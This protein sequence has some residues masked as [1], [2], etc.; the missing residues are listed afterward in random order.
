MPYVPS[1][2]LSTIQIDP[3][4]CV[5]NSLSTI[6]NN[7]TLLDFKLSSLALSA[8]LYWNNLYNITTVTSGVWNDLV[9]VVNENSAAWS[10]AY[11]AITAYSACWI[12][13][14]TLIFPNVVDTENLDLEA[15]KV[16]VSSWLN[17]N[18]PVSSFIDSQIVANYCIGQEL[19][20]FT[21]GYDTENQTVIPDSKNLKGVCTAKNLSWSWVHCAIKAGCGYYNGNIANAGT[22]YDLVGNP[23]DDGGTQINAG[24]GVKFTLDT[25]IANLESINTSIINYRPSLYNE[26]YLIF[27][28]NTGS[29]WS[30]TSL[31]SISS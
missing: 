13:P 15:H 25:S 24:G 28:N 27:K 23:T 5:G 29:Q 22:D 1:F 31:R 11:T 12:R 19:Y 6:N 17:A 8:E 14:V 7:F 9:T 2:S 4:E 21:M 20:I 10:S 3:A 18:F 30:Y 16:S 26:G